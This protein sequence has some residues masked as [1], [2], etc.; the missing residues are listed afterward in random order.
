VFGVQALVSC[1]PSR[2][3]AASRGHCACYEVLLPSEPERRNLYVDLYP[4]ISL[5]LSHGHVD[6]AERLLADRQVSASEFMHYC[7]C[8]DKVPALQYMLGNGHDRDLAGLCLLAAER[9]SVGCLRMLLDIGAPW[10]PEGLLYASR[11]NWLDVLDVVLDQNRE[12]S[13]GVPSLPSSAGNM[14]FL[15]RVF[16]AGCPIWTRAQ[17]GEPHMS[18]NGFIF[19]RLYLPAEDRSVPVEEL[20]LVVPSDLVYSG[21]VLLLAAQKGAP[22]TPRMEGML[23]EVRRRALAL[24]GCFHRAACLSRAP[25]AAARKWDAMGHVPVELVQ[26]IAT[27]ARLSIVA[28]ELVQ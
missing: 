14:R 16:N 22:M 13:P 1:C 28:V 17:D 24:A 11:D 8:N 27:L 5:A 19:R 21:P 3:E 4:C 12:W 15:M 9:G 23:V 26:S 25:G 20:S 2:R 6:F 10:D 18:C 7:T